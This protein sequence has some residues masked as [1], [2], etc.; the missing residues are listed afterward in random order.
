MFAKPIQQ[1]GCVSIE[2]KD[3]PKWGG[4]G[5]SKTWIALLGRSFSPASQK[6]NLFLKKA[7]KGW[8]GAFPLLK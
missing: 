1:R 3:S 8:F 6:I 4:L 5:L 2:T 7:A